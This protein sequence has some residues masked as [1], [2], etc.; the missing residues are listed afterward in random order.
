MLWSYCLSL[1]LPLPSTNWLF[2]DLGQSWGSFHSCT[3]ASVSLSQVSLL[4]T[5]QLPHLYTALWVLHIDVFFLLWALW[6]LLSSLLFYIDEHPVGL[7]LN[8]PLFGTTVI[9]TS[10]DAY[11]WSQMDKQSYLLSMKTWGITLWVKQLIFPKLKVKL[12]FLSGQWQN[13]V[14]IGEWLSPV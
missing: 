7:D 12:S 9:K 3:K 5:M 4:H 10:N 14:V 13:L 6:W 8:L 2:S 1:S 11:G